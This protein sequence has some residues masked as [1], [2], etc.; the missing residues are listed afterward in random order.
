MNINGLD[1]LVTTDQTSLAINDQVEPSSK[2]IASY[3][4]RVSLDPKRAKSRAGSGLEKKYSPFAIC[5][6]TTEAVPLK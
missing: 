6:S 1:I 4:P 5:N 2:A 3:T